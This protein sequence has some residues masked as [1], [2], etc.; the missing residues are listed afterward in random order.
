MRRVLKRGGRLSLLDADWASVSIGGGDVDLER[1]LMHPNST[2]LLRTA[3]LVD[4]G[5]QSFAELDE[6]LALVREMVVLDEIEAEAVA[7]GVASA[8]EIERWRR[9]L[10]DAAARGTFLA[11][12][13]LGQRADVDSHERPIFVA[14]GVVHGGAGVGAAVT[15]VGRGGVVDGGAGGAYDV[16]HHR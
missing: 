14:R 2:N 15:V 11:L 3:G 13:G 5:R 4:V 9:D 8:D 1:R 12:Q 10:H 16:A 7:R 6:D